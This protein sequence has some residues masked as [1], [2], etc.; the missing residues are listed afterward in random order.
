MITGLD[1]YPFEKLTERYDF[2]ADNN[3]NWKIFA[4]AFQEYYHVPVAAPAAGAVRG[5]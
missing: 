5:A 1:D 3:S 4:D 2:V